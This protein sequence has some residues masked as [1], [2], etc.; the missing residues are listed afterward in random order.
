MKIDARNIIA[1]SVVLPLQRNRKAEV[2]GMDVSSRNETHASESLDNKTTERNKAVETKSEKMEKSLGSKSESIVSKETS[3]SHKFGAEFEY[4]KLKDMETVV[5]KVMEK[6]QKLLEKK[7]KLWFPASLE[8]KFDFDYKRHIIEFES[9]NMIFSASGVLKSQDGSEV[10][11]QIGFAISR[12]FYSEVSSMGGFVNNGDKLALNFQEKNSQLTDVIFSFDISK[13]TPDESVGKG[14]MIINRADDYNRSQNVKDTGNQR[15]SK[16]WGKDMSLAYAKVEN[17]A[18][19][20][21][22]KIEMPS[23]S[24]TENLIDTIKEAFDNYKH[25]DKTI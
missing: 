9:Q 25:I 2:R 15:K 20:L 3:R 10:S 1:N 18:E 23:N 21:L 11:F 5:N 22:E 6:A 16:A 13:K 4:I 19:E 12:E 7:S 24:I 17:K 14:F 8:S